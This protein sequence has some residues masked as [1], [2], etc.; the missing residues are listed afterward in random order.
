MSL[1]A[2]ISNLVNAMEQTT[3]RAAAT[4]GDKVFLK[5]TKQGFWAFGADETEVEEDS[6]WA[7]NPNAFAT[8]Y[9]CWGDGELIDEAMAVITDAPIVKSELTQHSKPWADQVGLQLACLSGEDKG[10]QAVYTATSVG[11]KKAFNALLNEVLTRAK[12]GEEAI[13][14]VVELAADSYKHKKYGKVMVPVFNI[15]SWSKMDD[16]AETAAEPE[17]AAEPDEPAA[18]P[19][20]RRRSAA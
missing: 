12:E 1:P 2:N 13:V 7:I 3:A 19:K 20:R 14:P 15:V 4:T 5:L 10:L 16:V 6:R 9:A 11:G 8:G 17:P 18:K